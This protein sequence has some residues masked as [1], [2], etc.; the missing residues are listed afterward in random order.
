MLQI[1]LCGP[2]AGL[3]HL[4]RITPEELKKHNKP[5]DAWSAFQGKV[6]NLT[7]YLRY[8]PGG[9]DELMRVAGRDGTRLFSTFCSLFVSFRSEKGAFGLCRSSGSV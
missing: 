5:D 4:Q 6:Y 2:Q 9:V 1:W 3:S 7:P 8:H